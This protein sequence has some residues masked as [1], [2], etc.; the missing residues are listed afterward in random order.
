MSKSDA[1]C[2]R[3]TQIQV[4]GL[5]KFGTT[6]QFTPPPPAIHTPPYTYIYIQ[7][8]QTHHTTPHTIA[9]TLWK[10]LPCAAKPSLNA[11]FSSS[12]HSV[13][14]PK[15]RGCCLPPSSIRAVRA[16]CV[17]I[18]LGLVGRYCLSPPSSTRVRFGWS[19][20]VAPLVVKG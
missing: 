12:L 7:H 6:S 4:S 2:L 5:F 19:I 11:L 18:W 15:S 13:A 1:A 8:T 17:C 16:L 9:W 14:T 20:L 3:G 10:I